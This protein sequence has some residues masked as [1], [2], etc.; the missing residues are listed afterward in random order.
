[1]RKTQILWTLS[2]LVTSTCIHAQEFEA[3]IQLRPRYEYRHGFKIFLQEGEKPTSF[4]SQRTRINL[5][6]RQ[7]KLQLYF[8]AQNVGIWGEKPIAS[9]SDV[10]ATSIHEAWG[11]YNFTKHFA[12]KIGRQVLSYDNQRI[13]GGLDWA[14]QGQSHD[15]LLLQYSRHVHRLDMGFALNN[16]EEALQKEAY[17]VANYKAMQYLWYH[18]QIR[19]LHL[20]FL[21][22]NTGYEFTQNEDFKT[23]YFQTWG[24]YLSYDKGKFNMNAGFYGQSGKTTQQTKEAWYAGLDLAYQWHT[25][26]SSQVGYEFLSGKRQNDTSNCNKSF[27]P[28]F[29]TNH[30][31]NGLM[32]YFYA[33]N[34][35]NSVGLHDL[36]VK[37]HW[38]QDKWTLSVQ[39][40]LFHSASQIYD[41]QAAAMN[42]YLGTEFDVT[43]DYQLQ[44]D[45]KLSGGF[46]QLFASKSLETLKGLLNDRNNQWVW[47][48]VNILPTVFKSKK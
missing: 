6:Y 31:F 43:L 29:G 9:P 27:T 45:I 28:V 46:S 44:K 12:F 47:L 48:M 22:L 26:F 34:H 10:N 7:K 16:A 15:A 18:T 39:P 13:F 8:S 2:F 21:I 41:S 14:Q 35:L 30:G 19:S 40:H 32:D 5:N 33:G 4:V 23:E 36:Y 20:S 11:K 24:T 1:M 17:T 42:S 37:L 38:R 25:S 3:D